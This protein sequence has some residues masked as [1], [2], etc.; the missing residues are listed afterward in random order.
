[1]PDTFLDYKKQRYRWAYGSVQIM[2]RHLREL[3]GL[4]GSRL[5]RGQRYHFLAGW[6]PW[7]ADGLNL[8]YTL[9]A[10]AW[11]AAIIIDPRH[12]DPPLALL[13]SALEETILALALIAAAT[14][15][16]WV[17]GKDF[18]GSIL[19]G[20]ALCVQSLPYQA[21]LLMA[22]TNASAGDTLNRQVSL[23]SHVNG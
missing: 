1:M 7:M 18:T 20:L 3:I 6:L 14:G 11:S 15:V 10:L 5:T 23:T 12:T 22:L 16:I 9:A 2:R 13:C 8:F 4:N 21:A 17:Q 19:W